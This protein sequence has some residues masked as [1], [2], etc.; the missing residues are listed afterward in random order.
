MLTCR[1]GVSCIWCVLF[2]GENK[3]EGL[4]RVSQSLRFSTVKNGIVMEL[5]DTVPMVYLFPE[6][7]FY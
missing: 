4:L 2:H 5:C 7:V 1:W 6:V 3:Q